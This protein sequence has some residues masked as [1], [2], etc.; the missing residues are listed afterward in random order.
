MTIAED[1]IQFI[2]KTLHNPREHNGCR[3]YA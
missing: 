3:V 1:F 2:F